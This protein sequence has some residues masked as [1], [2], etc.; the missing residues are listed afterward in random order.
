MGLSKHDVVECCKDKYGYY[1]ELHYHPELVGSWYNEFR[2]K[3]YYMIDCR[4]EEYLFMCDCECE[5]KVEWELTYY[6]LR[7]IPL[8][9]KK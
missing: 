1:L 9:G 3:Y 6:R 4:L 2:R 8:G 5:V 7:F